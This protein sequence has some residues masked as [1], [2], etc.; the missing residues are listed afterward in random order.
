MIAIDLLVEKNEIESF[1]SK[2]VNSKIISVDIE[3]MRRNTFFPEPCVIQISDGSN[4]GCIDLTLQLSYKNIFKEIFNTNKIIVLHSCRQD[5]EI[6]YMILGYIPKNIFDTQFAASF[7]GYKY[8]I[9]YAELMKEVYGVI[10]DKTEKMTNWKKRPLSKEQINYAVNDVI[11]L[12]KL[13]EDLNEELLKTKKIKYFK[14][15][16][17]NFI[18]DIEWNPKTDEA[19]KRI[20]SINNLNK[21]V[22]NIVKI[23]SVWRERQAINR[24]IPRNWIMSEKEIIEISKDFIINKK[25]SLPKNNKYF[26][27]DM[28]Q[29]EIQNAIDKLCANK[30]F[31]KDDGEKT[32]INSYYKKIANDLYDYYKLISLENNISY[33]ILSP[34]KMIFSY[35][36]NKDSNSRLINGWRKELIDIKKISSITQPYFNLE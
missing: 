17:A 6:L 28:A 4:H 3:F 12:N 5:L 23:I 9:G 10:I 13:Y 32:K 11:H 8:Q 26:D 20:K 31:D 19:W 2:V 34:K 7:L 16:F 18:N 1:I 27:Y 14:E 35:L 33:Q 15:E 30:I 24:D 21:N 36:K 29:L 25:V 22:K